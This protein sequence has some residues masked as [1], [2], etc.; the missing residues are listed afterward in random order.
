MNLHPT[1][2]A[3]TICKTGVSWKETGVFRFNKNQ[4]FG[5]LISP[6]GKMVFS[7]FGDILFSPLIPLTHPF[8]R[9][10]SKSPKGKI[11]TCTKRTKTVENTDKKRNPAQK[12]N[13]SL[14][15]YQEVI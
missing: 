4:S 3:M 1:P 9:N 2:T 13:S 10:Q 7:F 8:F 12:P 14:C 6:D 11:R 15:K 5:I